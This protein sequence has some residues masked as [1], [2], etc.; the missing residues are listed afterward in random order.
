MK[1]GICRQKCEPSV[2]MTVEGVFSNFE[3]IRS[4]WPEIED[5]LLGKN[6]SRVHVRAARRVRRRGEGQL[7]AR[8][9]A[10]VVT[11]EL[12]RARVDGLRDPDSDSKGGLRLR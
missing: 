10:L 6:G 4:E 2:R 11:N 1:I 12:D 7:R 9:T 8:G 3:G 5:S